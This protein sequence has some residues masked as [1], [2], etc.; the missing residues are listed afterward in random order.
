MGGGERPGR[1]RALQEHSAKHSR[2]DHGVEHPV[3][4]QA[5]HAGAGQHVHRLFHE[6]GV[7][8][9][10]DR[11]GRTE[12]GG[13]AAWRAAPGKQEQR[14][15]GQAPGA[16]GQQP[17]PGVRDSAALAWR[18]GDQE[19]GQPQ[20]DQQSGGPGPR[21]Y[22]V[23]QDEDPQAEREDQLEHEDRLH[24]RQRAEVQ[25]KRLEPERADKEEGPEEPDRLADQVDHGPP[26]RPR[27]R[28][29]RVHD[30]EP[31]QHCAARARQSRQGGEENSCGH[32]RNPQLFP[33]AHWAAMDDGSGVS[34]SFH[35]SHGSEF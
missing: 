11:G 33:A 28:G 30:G 12:K 21:G 19:G 17:L 16:D 4:Q 26:A 2:R 27:R 20:A 32:Q 6:R 24:H 18:R 34:F 23:M 8:R 10:D 7:H 22:P 14:R 31:L 5:R 3:R 1:V 9:P 35:D 29:L 25:G 13:P 15:H